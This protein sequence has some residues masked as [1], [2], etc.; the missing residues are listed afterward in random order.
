MHLGLCLRSLFIGIS[1][2][3]EKCDVKKCFLLGIAIAHIK[4]AVTSG[5]LVA[6]LTV[7]S[8]L[9]IQWDALY[10]K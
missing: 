4:Y 6:Q 10:L 8:E 3:S 7:G 1:V 9:Q 5:I 2:A